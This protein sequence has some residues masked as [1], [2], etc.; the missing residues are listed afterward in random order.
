MVTRAKPSGAPSVAPVSGHAALLLLQPPPEWELTD[1]RFV[2]LCEL[3]P[4]LRF[5]ID[6]RGRL[7][8]TD[9][10]GLRSSSRALRI[11]GQVD[12][13]ALADGGGSVT[14]ADG[15]YHLGE[16]TLRAPGAAWVSAER[17]ASMES[18]DERIPHLCPDFVVEI[19]S[20][21]DRLSDQR[22]K[23]ELWIE[24][25][26]RLAWLIDP[27]AGTAHIYRPE[28]EPELLQRPYSLSGE[29]VLPGLVVDL[30]RVWRDQPEA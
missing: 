14:G 27:F 26:A 24:H 17:A 6:E 10:A 20:P 21:S 22:T 9:R 18:D 25:G 12:A 2:E 23:L 7:S 11:G 30:S 4:G 16:H 28:R 8:I 29:D 1:E 3:N 13:W 5:E 15:F 19:R